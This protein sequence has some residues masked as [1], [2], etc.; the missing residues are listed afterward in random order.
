[1]GLGFGDFS[2]GSHTF[3]CGG[4]TPFRSNSDDRAII[5]AHVQ[6]EL[7]TAVHDF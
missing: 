2:P 7:K 5:E 4:N 1:M 3:A 6:W